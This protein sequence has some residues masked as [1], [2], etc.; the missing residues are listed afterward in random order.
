MKILIA[1]DSEPVRRGVR[2]ILASQTN[3]EIC[4]EAKDGAEAIQRAAELRPDFVLLDIS[5][6]GMSGLEVA[7][8]L[9]EKLPAVK[10]I[11][12]SQHDAAVLLPSA[13][14]AGADACIDKSR[15]ALDLAPAIERLHGG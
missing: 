8:F 15:L 10:I 4:A 5:M 14:Q 11:V 12:M 1:D 2:S 7:S 3:W 13:L 9:R 6:P